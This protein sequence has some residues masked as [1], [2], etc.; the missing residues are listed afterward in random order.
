MMVV[1]GGARGGGLAPVVVVG[2]GVAGWGGGS[3][4]GMDTPKPNPCIPYI[5][6]VYVRTLLGEAEVGEPHVAPR[7]QQDVLGLQVPVGVGGSRMCVCERL[8]DGRGTNQPTN[9]LNPTPTSHQRP[10]PKA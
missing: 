2:L 10:Q 8:I 9:P 6:V 4:K 1:V 7:V 3:I 5:H